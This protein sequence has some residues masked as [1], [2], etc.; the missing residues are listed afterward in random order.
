M[1]GRQDPR[2]QT[3]PSRWVVP[4][5][6]HSTQWAGPE[7]CLAGPV[8]HFPVDPVEFTSQGWSYLVQALLCLDANLFANRD[9]SCECPSVPPLLVRIRSLQQALLG[10]TLSTAD[11]VCLLLHKILAP[12][13]LGVTQQLIHWQY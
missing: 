12:I 4:P 5:A 9:W 3:P 6:A 10:G 7:A 1:R 8:Q 11:Q 13:M 2:H